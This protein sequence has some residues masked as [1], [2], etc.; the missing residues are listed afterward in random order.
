MAPKIISGFI[1]NSFDPYKDNKVESKPKSIR[2]MT[3][4][5]KMDLKLK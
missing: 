2:R 4:M 1:K 3:Y 5:E